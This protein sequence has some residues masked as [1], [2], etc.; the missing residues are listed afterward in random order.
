MIMSLG[1]KLAQTLKKKYCTLQDLGDL[2][3]SVSTN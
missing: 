2:T 3:D 1:V